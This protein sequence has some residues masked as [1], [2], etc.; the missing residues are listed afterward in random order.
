MG[1]AQKIKNKAKKIL[2]G[3]HMTKIRT[4]FYIFILLLLLFFTFNCFFPY[5]AMA[6]PGPPLPPSLL[7]L[8]HFQ[9]H[10]SQSA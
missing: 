4:K 2:G 6:H 8:S 3:D 10:T 5:F 1:I 9:V 7:L